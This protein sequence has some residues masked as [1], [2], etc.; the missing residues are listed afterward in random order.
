MAVM[1]KKRDTKADAA[2]DP[3]LELKP[4]LIEDLDPANQDADDIPGGSFCGRTM[5]TGGCATG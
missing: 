5:R 3:G 4:A 1:T 2:V